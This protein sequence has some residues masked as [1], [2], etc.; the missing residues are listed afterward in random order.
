MVRLSRLAD[1][2]VVL[3]THMA[4]ERNMVLNAADAATA[5]GVPAPTVAKVL[6]KLAAAGLVAGQRGAKGGYRL[7]RAPETV[8]IADIVAAIDGPIAL[9]TCFK[10][11]DMECGVVAACPSRAGLAR[12]NAAIR[13]ALDAVSLAEI[14][15]PVAAFAQPARSASP[16]QVSA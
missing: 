13:G 7:S 12:I 1:Y 11:G 2:G 10:A 5:T 9:T 4:M 15:Q 8:S 16:L 14:A 6:K 3:L